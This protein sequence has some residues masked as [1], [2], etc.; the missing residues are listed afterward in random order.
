VS[1][2]F[3][4]PVRV[5]DVT[6]QRE[7]QRL[8]LPAGSHISAIVPSPNRKHVFIT[9]WGDGRRCFWTAWEATTGKLVHSETGLPPGSPKLAVSPDGASLALTIGMSIPRPPSDHTE[10]R[11]Y[12]VRGWKER[13]RWQAHRGDDAGRCSI[14]F[15]PDGK[16]LA[17]GGADGKVRRWDAATGKEISPAIDPVQ[18]HCQNVAYLDADTLMT[19]GFQQT[20]KLWEATTGKPKR[21]FVGSELG[22]TALAYAPD[23]RHVAA[24]GGDAPIRVWE[25]DSG[26]LVAQLWDGEDNVSCLHFSRDGKWLLSGDYLGRARLWDWARGGAPIKSFRPGSSWDSVAFS[27]DGNSVAASDFNGAI[28]VWAIPTGKLLRTLNVSQ[29][30]LGQH[31][32][33]FALAFSANGQALFGSISGK[34][35]RHWSLA[36][37][38]EVR[39]IGPAS[40]AHS[41]AVSALALS[42]AGRWGYSSCYDG[43]VCVWEAGSGRLARTLNEKRPGHNGPVV[44]ALSPDGT[45]LA[46]AFQN[47]WETCSIHL[48]DLPSGQKV[49]LTGH[50]APVT[51]LAFSRNGY[52]LASA[53]WDTT[54]LVWDVSGLNLGGK[55]PDSKTLAGLWKDLGAADAK[56]VYAAV[57]RGAAAGDVAVLRLKLDLKPAAAID[58]DK[59]ADLVLQ[60]DAD[61]FAQREQAS[62]AL[63]DLGPAAEA[64]LREV[65]EKTGSLE[66]RRRLERALNECEAQYRRMGHAVE[67]L[68]MIGTPAARSLLADLAKG[69][70]GARLTRDARAALDRLE[71]RW[72]K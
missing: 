26:K 4:G 44:L 58:P 23:G 34:G 47:D 69:A 46:A 12:S 5:W 42:P 68:E 27:P 54:V 29:G 14:A 56:V 13:R 32:R 30:P 19:F 49:T 40:L 72:G 64:P 57:C 38:K 41:N 25:A 55:A 36:T 35:I 7:L 1:G 20:V 65:L 48:W 60:L 18:Q 22:V 39:L 53:S 6:R 17:T 37:G 45:R 31:E 43:S 50:S 61:D 3:Y 11:L 33:V 28:R 66:V 2:G 51:Q 24:G 10:I 59:V 62:R 52:R 71:Q 67:V 8:P 9:G 15:S 70:G 63:A 21:V 16:T